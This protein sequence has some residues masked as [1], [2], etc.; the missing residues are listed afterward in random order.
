MFDIHWVDA[1][2]QE[3]QR[4][5]G[6]PQCGETGPGFQVQMK[7]P[8]ALTLRAHRLFEKRR[9]P[10]A[11]PL[12]I[13]LSQVLAAKLPVS[14]T[15]PELPIEMTIW[16]RLVRWSLILQSTHRIDLGGTLGRDVAREKAGAN[17]ENSDGSKSPVIGRGNARNEAGEET[18][19]DVAGDET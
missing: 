10:L 14:M 18:R 13:G 2:G 12:G 9:S 17:R 11:F 5:Y 4:A 1:A 16:C 8:V 3:I 15:S 6:C 7:T 19:G